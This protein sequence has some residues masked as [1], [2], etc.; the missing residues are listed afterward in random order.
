[1]AR[2]NIRADLAKAC[3]KIIIMFFKCTDNPVDRLPWSKHGEWIE[4][5][6]KDYLQGR[7]HPVHSRTCSSLFKFVDEAATA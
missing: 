1:M 4:A 3:K 5:N 6:A 7:Q 2:M